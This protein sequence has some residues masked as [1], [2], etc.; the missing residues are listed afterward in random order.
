MLSLREI[1]IAFVNGVLSG[2]PGALG[3]RIAEA[4][5]LNASARLDIYRNNSFGNW[6]GALQD[7]YPVV[8]ALVGE[9]FFNQ[10]ADLYSRRYPSRSGNLHDFGSEFAAFLADYS[11]AATLPYLPDVARLEWAIHRV[12][13]AGES[14]TLDLARLAAVAPE[15]LGALRFQLNPATALV[16]SPYPILD[17]WRISQPDASSNRTVDLAAGADK[18]LVIRRSGDIDIERLA[19]GEF[20]LLDALTGGCTLA[21]AM[22]QTL[23]AQPDFNLEAALQAHVGG[24]TLREFHDNDGGTR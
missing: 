21:E 23:D 7:V 4:G 24:Q 22:A 6:R 8:L 15:R 12:F 2:A 16:S 14:S 1:Q 19:L 18:L 10:A 3:D 17:I 9:S 13:H 11:L 20:I 5:G